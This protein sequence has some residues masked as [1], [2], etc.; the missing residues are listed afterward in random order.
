MTYTIYIDDDKLVNISSTKEYAT[1]LMEFYATLI[2]NNYNKSC[3][4]INKNIYKKDINETT[5]HII[6]EYNM[7]FKTYVKVK[8]KIYVTEI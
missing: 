7:L 3:C 1:Q 8:H 6:I 2:C 5:I 4:T